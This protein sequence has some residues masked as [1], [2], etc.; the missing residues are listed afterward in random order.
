MAVRTSVNQPYQPRP[1]KFLLEY[2]KAWTT[3][4]ENNLNLGAVEV[5]D[6]TKMLAYGKSL[7]GGKIWEVYQG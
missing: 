3:M 6:V 1:I 7:L 5:V 4:L 2:N